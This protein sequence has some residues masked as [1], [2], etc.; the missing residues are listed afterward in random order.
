MNN[1]Q[2]L[3]EIV[4]VDQS[5][6]ACNIEIKCPNKERSLSY[7]LGVTVPTPTEDPEIIFKE[8]CYTHRIFADVNSSED[9][10][11]DYSSFYHQRQLS[12]ESVEF[13]LYHYE[14]DNEYILDDGV[15]GL[16]FGYGSFSSNINLTG[17]MVEWKKVLTVIGEGNFQIIKRQNIAGIDVELKSIVFTLKQFSNSACALSS[18]F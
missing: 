13:V 8:C 16:F 12:N 10:K 18:A 11:N 3:L 15:F 4:H 17:F 7:A 1:N 6:L 14:L 9:F 5:A 2:E